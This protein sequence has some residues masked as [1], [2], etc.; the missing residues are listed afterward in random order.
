M[1]M[2]LARQHGRILDKPEY[3]RIYQMLRQW[4]PSEKIGQIDQVN[5]GIAEHIVNEEKRILVLVNYD[6][7]PAKVQVQLQEGWKVGRML[8]GTLEIPGNDCTVVECEREG[9]N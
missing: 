8:R 2:I 5:V 9:K 6:P 1:E 4:M 3:Y 7:E